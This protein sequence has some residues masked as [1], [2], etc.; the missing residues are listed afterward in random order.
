M[1]PQCDVGLSAEEISPQADK[2]VKT[3]AAFCQF[4]KRYACEM[5]F[6][7][8]LYGRLYGDMF[9]KMEEIFLFSI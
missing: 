5:P 9:D 7:H 4:F 2:R 6:L 3:E 1:V 8:L